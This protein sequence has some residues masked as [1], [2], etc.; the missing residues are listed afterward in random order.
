LGERK[1][2]SGIKGI[3]PRCGT[4]YYGWALNE[5]VEHKC[6]HCGINLAIVTATISGNAAPGAAE[7]NVKNGIMINGGQ[8]SNKN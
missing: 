7:N 8:P 2:M 5:P 6:E 3:C 1:Q 4:T